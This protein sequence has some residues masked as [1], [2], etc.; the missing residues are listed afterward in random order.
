MLRGA[1]ARSYSRQL[2]LEEVWAEAEAGGG[3]GEGAGEVGMRRQAAVKASLSRRHHRP[4]KETRGGCGG[5][6][7]RAVAEIL[8]SGQHEIAVWRRREKDCSDCF[9]IMNLW[10]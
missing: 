4:E 1:H 2:C 8:K 6:S 7:M 5:E 3:E 9:R 10:T